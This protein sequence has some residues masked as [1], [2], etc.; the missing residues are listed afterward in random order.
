MAY[1]ALSPVAAAVYAVLN[2]A[3]VTPALVTGVHDD[4]PQGVAFP[5]MLL[6]V[7]ERDV[8]GFGTGGLPEV[9]LRVHTFSAYEG[10]KQAQAANQKAIELLRDQELIVAGYRFCGRVF[11]DE[12][13]LLPD[14]AINGVKCHE[15]V[16]NFRIY[17][18][19]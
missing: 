8:R 12:T 11:Y 1:L 19:E 13:V 7:Q 2:V 14:E 5:F 3:S 4:I 9:T 10:L 17:V 16:S 15:I 6:E 18:E